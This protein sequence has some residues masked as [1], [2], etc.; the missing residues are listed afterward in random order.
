MLELY[1]SGLSANSLKVRLCLAEKG[2]EYTGFF[3]DLHKFEQHAPDYL[4]INP[5]GQIPT[6]LD[7][8]QAITE[9]SVINE[10]LDDV[11]PEIPLR[12]KDAL[13]R[14]RMRQ[15]SKLVDESLFPA[16]S[17]IGW[18]RRVRLSVQALD[19]GELAAMLD[20]VPLKEKRDKWASAARPGGFSEAELAESRRRIVFFVTRMEAALKAGGPWLAGGHYSLADINTL[21]FL[22][23]LHLLA[24]G[25]LGEA[26][27]PRLQDWLERLRAR[28]AVEK[29]YAVSD[30]VPPHK[31]ETASGQVIGP[32]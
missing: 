11:F 30:Q 8:G 2:L 27:T 25:I 4:A 19:A 31:H 3:I 13:A 10:Y 32:A 1:H 6:L 9:T 22:N 15:W 16:V 21:P 28:P 18:Q 20:R 17:M 5:D 12:P 14:A 23:R 7:D 29:T 26:E 24:P